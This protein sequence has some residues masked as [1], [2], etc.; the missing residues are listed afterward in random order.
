MMVA[1][2]IRSPPLNRSVLKVWFRAPA[3]VPVSLKVSYKAGLPLND[4]LMDIDFEDAIIRY[5]NIALPQLPLES[6]TAPD[7][8]AIAAAL[9]LQAGDIGGDFKPACW[10]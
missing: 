1:C 10:A 4:G 9:G 7:A 8:S 6:G 5:A 3:A 2:P